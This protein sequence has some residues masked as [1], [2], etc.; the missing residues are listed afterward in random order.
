MFSR[1]TTTH[2]ICPRS[3]FLISEVTST[4]ALRVG[5]IKFTPSVSQSSI[6][7]FW[8]RGT[9]GGYICVFPIIISDASYTSTGTCNLPDLRSMRVQKR[10]SDGTYCCPAGR[11]L[12]NFFLFWLEG[13]NATSLPSLVFLLEGQER[14]TYDALC[15]FTNTT[16]K[17][18][19]QQYEGLVLNSW[20]M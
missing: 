16:N 14:L 15:N 20:K 17:S 12:W 19:K 1:N 8:D 6:P 3:D 4:V 13:R 11:F 9:H 18:S 2:S 7:F 10:L 5:R